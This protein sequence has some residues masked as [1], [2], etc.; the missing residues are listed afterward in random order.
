VTLHT[1]DLPEPALRA[2]RAGVERLADRPEYGDRGLG[3]ADP[4]TLEAAVPHDV[5]TLG[6]DEIADG[7]GLGSAEPVGRRVLVMEGERAVATAELTDPVGGEGFSATEGPYTETT[8]RAVREVEGW[9]VVVDGEYDLR[10]L[11]LPALYLMALWLKDRDGDAD[12]LVPL[13]PA[14]SGTEAG[15][16]YPADELLTE[17]RGRARELLASQDDERS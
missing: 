9:P 16:G 11:R 12:M 1:P 3:G 15:R 6:L 14:P 4:A 2:I 8:A 13:D 7:K 5:Y 17:L 10:V